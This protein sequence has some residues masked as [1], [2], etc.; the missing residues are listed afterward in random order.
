M[1]PAQKWNIR[2]A[3]A[4]PDGIDL[5]ELLKRGEEA[6]HCRRLRRWLRASLLLNILLAAAL[7]GLLAHL[8]SSS[9]HGAVPTTTA[10]LFQR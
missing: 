4:R 2:T 6:F 8:I 7:S 10:P 3:P 9:T 1:S 5:E